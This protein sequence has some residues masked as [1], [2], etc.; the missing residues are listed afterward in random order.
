[1][2]E[3]ALMVDE[4]HRAG[5]GVILDWV[6]AHF[7]D[8]EH[9][10]ADFDGSA[11]FEYADPREGRHPEWGSR[12]FDWGRPEVRA[13]LVS[14]ARWWIERY[15]VEGRRVD[16]VA[17]MLYRDYGRRDGEWVPNRHGGRENLEAIDFVRQLTAEIH[18]S[19]PGAIVIAEESTA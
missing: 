2:A 10:L 6:P 14:S 1:P 15:P 19:T 9:G 18:R 8:D 17:S 13:F 12:V 3:F 16:A 11:L 5:I 4:L 7:P